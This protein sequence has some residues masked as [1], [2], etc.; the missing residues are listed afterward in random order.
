MC[1]EAVLY[2]CPT[3]AAND[4]TELGGPDGEYVGA[5]DDGQRGSLGFGRWVVEVD[6][7][8]GCG[9]IVVIYVIVISRS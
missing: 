6:V 9:K 2:E 7:E 4:V 8:L 1:V 5:Y 3:G